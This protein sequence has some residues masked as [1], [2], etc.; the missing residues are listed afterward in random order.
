L[1]DA[2]ARNFNI[3]YVKNHDVYGSWYISFLDDGEGMDPGKVIRF[4]YFKKRTLNNYVGRI[5]AG[6]KTYIFFILF[7]V[8]LILDFYLI[9]K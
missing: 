9:F 4:L 7:L 3:N 8:F 1:R 2:Q 5:G 6:L